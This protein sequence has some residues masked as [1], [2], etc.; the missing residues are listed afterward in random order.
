MSRFLKNDANT[1]TLENLAEDNIRRLEEINASII[2]GSDLTTVETNTLNT[3]NNTASID[4]TST[5]MDGRLANIETNI[6]IIKQQQHVTFEGAGLKVSTISAQLA[7]GIVIGNKRFTAIEMLG[8]KRQIFNTLTAM[9]PLFGTSVL[10]TQPFPFIP[11][12]RDNSVLV[13]VSSSDAGDTNQVGGTGMRVILLLGYDSNGLFTSELIAL[14]GQTPVTSVN[15]YRAMY[16]FASWDS[17]DLDNKTGGP[18]I[19]HV[20]ISEDGAALTAGV[21][22]VLCMATMNA[23]DGLGY[24]G[25]NFYPAG[26][27][28]TS[29]NDV[30]YSS[31]LFS[32][33]SSGGANANL[34]I[35]FTSRDYSQL[36]SSDHAG[37]W[38]LF[39]TLFVSTDNQSSGFQQSAFPSTKLDP[40]QDTVTLMMVQR[41]SGN[42]DDILISAYLSGMHVISA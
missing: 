27:D 16:L 35:S 26:T 19:G 11:S 23:S 5:T 38:R 30:F 34:Q 24:C 20:F 25:Y 39:C 40:L 1:S 36:L 2:S 31:F 8:K 4:T 13:Q 17:W 18:N 33:S 14:N 12:S 32:S 37:G 21:P 41:L 42:N 9:A 28:M 7:P 10:P 15:T 3:A 22:D 6:N 29:T